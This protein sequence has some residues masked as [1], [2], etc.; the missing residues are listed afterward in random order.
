MNNYLPR[1][2]KS[3][4]RFIIFKN[5]NEFDF[6][7]NYFELDIFIN[8]ISF[9]NLNKFMNRHNFI[10]FED[11]DINQKN[12]YHFYGYDENFKSF[13]HLHVHKNIII[14]ESLSKN[15]QFNYRLYKNDIVKIKN[16]L[17]S[18]NHSNL[19]EI[20]L[21]RYY[22]K[23]S[24]II[25]FPVYLS[26]SDEYKVEKGY[27]I[28][29]YQLNSKKRILSN[30]IFEE[31]MVNL[32]SNFIIKFLLGCK[33]KL[34][35]NKNKINSSLVNNINLISRIII[36]LLKRIFKLS[37]KK[38]LLKKGPI[39]AICGY[40]AS[41]KTT[42]AN[43]IEKWLNKDFYVYR[44]NISKN[45]LLINLNN[46]FKTK[47]NLNKNFSKS[48]IQNLFKRIGY[49]FLSISRFLKYLLIEYHSKKGAIVIV[50]RYIA[51]LNDSKIDSQ[52]IN[53]QYFLSKK[54]EDFF[55]N[56]IKK[57]NLVLFLKSDIKELINRN[58]LRVK[59]FKENTNQI[60]LRFKLAQN[61]KYKSKKIIYFNNN[62]NLSVTITK[63]KKIIWSE[64][65]NAQ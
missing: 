1:I 20:F 14:G 36:I 46:F 23:I 28:K 4:E 12:I 39:I 3:N 65:I 38:S 57:A 26:K 2:F 19:F 24:N 37:R 54:F 18:L 60:K 21:I 13:I 8:G 32:E 62:K 43:E 34:L 55:Y 64:I 5:M 52:N 61:L 48:G 25:N 6:F 42:I 30:K 33:L 50:D 63:I 44:S 40:D 16:N 56:K 51:E 41:G 29:K 11:K 53:K 59:S 58:N 31:L 35:I 10:L 45:N 17:Y 47:R 7:K 9:R 15:Y 22:L 49:I 27:L